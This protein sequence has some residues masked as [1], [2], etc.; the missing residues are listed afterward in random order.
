VEPR[1]FEQRVIGAAEVLAGTLGNRPNHTIAAAGVDTRG[2]IHT[3]VNVRHFTGGPCAELVVLGVAAAANAGPLVAMAAAGNQSRGLIAPC[4]RCRQVM[5]DLHPDVL[6]AVPTADGPRMRPIAKLVSDVHVL[7]DTDAERVL[8]FH[9]RYYESVAAGTKTSSVRWDESVSVGP[10]ILYFED[11][12]RPA[13][14]GQIS[15]VNRYNIDTLT[16]ERLRLRDGDTVAEYIDGL[17]QHYPT[18]PPSAEVDVVDF[19]VRSEQ[20]I[21]RT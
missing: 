10:A 21:P 11:D 9:K 8:R 18:M 14:R 3:A 16:P 15:A 13:L 17:R 7:P 4:G 5:I 19:I 20:R 12:E 6:V 1:G 2:G